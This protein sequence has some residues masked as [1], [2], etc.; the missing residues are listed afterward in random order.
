M[1]AARSTS[2]AD[3]FHASINVESLAPQNGRVFIYGA[4]S[5]AERVGR[6]V[7]AAG[8]DIVAYIDDKAVGR[9][10]DG[11][12]VVGSAEIAI[13]FDAGDCVLLALFNPLADLAVVFA[14]L[15]CLAPLRIFSPPQ[16]LQ[17]FPDAGLDD[18][19]LAS[20]AIYQAMAKEV[21]AHRSLWADEESR[22]NYE[23]IWCYRLTG[24]IAH[25][26]APDFDGQYYPEGLRQQLTT[27]R[28]VDCGAFE[29][30]TLSMLLEQGAPLNAVAAFEP[31]PK[32]YMRMIDQL[33]FHDGLLERVISWPCGVWSSAEQLSFSADRGGA[34][35]LQPNGNSVI[36]CVALDQALAGFAPSYIKMDV[37][38]AELQALQGAHN[39]IVEHRPALAISAYHRPEDLWKLPAYLDDLDLGYR[40]YLRLHGHQ[41]FDAVFYAIS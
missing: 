32:N 17:A 24:N 21:L 37:E 3:L 34:S 1:M 16:I 38:G 18:Y 10:I 28:F 22:Q 31:D 8:Y 39:L 15:A 20:P 29:G 25:L 6:A 36:Q 26:I 13:E 12:A 30:D 23:R 14:N 19:W 40:F 5:Y 11:H 35:N 27:S 2:L 33:G 4:G 41:G 9:L 7:S